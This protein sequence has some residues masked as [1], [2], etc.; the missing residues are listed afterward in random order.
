[1]VEIIPK[2][3]EKGIPF[4]NIFLFIA[5]ALLL[6]A[7]LSYVFLIRLEVKVLSA[8]EDINENIAKI[9]DREDRE[10]EKKVFDFEKKFLDLKVLLAG[11]QKSLGFFDN[12][13]T[14][15]HPQVWFSSLELDVE[16]KR[17][18]ANGTTRDFRT[19]EQQLIFLRGQQDMVSSFELSGLSFGKEDGVGFNLS[20]SFTPKIFNS[21]GK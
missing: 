17:A 4:K 6:A 11:R 20:F 15:V 21:S 1:M 2:K 14:L 13:G 3:P 19:L 5:L 18:T 8:I 7:I 16:G 10:I 12:F 9:G